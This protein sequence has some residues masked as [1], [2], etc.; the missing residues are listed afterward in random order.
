MSRRG[1]KGGGRTM[2]H[3]FVSYSHRDGKYLDDRSL[4]GHLQGLRKDG[5]EFWHDT[6]LRAGDDW[7][8]TIEKEIECADIA[9][10]LVSQMFLNSKY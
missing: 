6:S 2:V 10:V 5:V 4:L 9:L 8:H 1:S 3:I 7:D